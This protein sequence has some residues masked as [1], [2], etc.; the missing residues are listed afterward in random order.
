MGKAT[1]KMPSNW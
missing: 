1:R